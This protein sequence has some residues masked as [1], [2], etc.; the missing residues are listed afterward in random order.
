MSDEVVSDEVMSAAVG[1]ALVEALAFLSYA[2]DEADDDLIDSDTL[3]GWMEVVGGLLGRLP[4]RDR[5]SLAGVSRRLARR[6]A[7][8]EM[9]TACLRFVAGYGLDADEG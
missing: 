5:R 6:S 4:A 3:V 2:M 7:D 9:R 1:E 8:E